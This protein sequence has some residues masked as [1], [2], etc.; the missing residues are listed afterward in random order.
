[1]FRDIKK[2]LGLSQIN[3]D[4]RTLALWP[5]YLEA[6]W[7]GLKPVTQSDEYRQAARRP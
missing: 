3:S 5:D 1:V 4:Y 2:T 7:K 6:A